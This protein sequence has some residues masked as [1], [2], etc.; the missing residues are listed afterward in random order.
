MLLLCCYCCV[1]GQLLC[2]CSVVV[3]LLCCYWGFPLLLVWCSS[4]VTAVLWC[5]YCDVPVLLLHTVILWCYWMFRC[6]YCSGRVLLLL[7]LRA[8]CYWAVTVL[9]LQYYYAVP[10]LF[11]RCYCG[12]VLLSLWSLQ[13]QT[14]TSSSSFWR[15]LSR[16]ESSINFLHFRNVHKATRDLELVVHSLRLA[17]CILQGSAWHLT[18]VVSKGCCHASCTFLPLE[19]ISCQLV[20]QNVFVLLPKKTHLC[21]LRWIHWR[22]VFLLASKDFK[23]KQNTKNK[24]NST[25]YM[26][27]KWKITVSEIEK[28]EREG[29]HTLRKSKWHIS[30]GLWLINYILLNPLSPQSCRHS[31]RERERKRGG[32]GGEGDKEWWKRSN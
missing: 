17:S 20:F 5:Y 22:A 30:A 6:C 4:S 32:V 27:S 16:F 24:R 29:S 15:E 25:L 3:V 23:R 8:V 10:V 1:T 18:S 9:L 28:K 19:V 13:G 7:F 2:Y 21:H 12:T 31:E 11:L 14:R 26:E